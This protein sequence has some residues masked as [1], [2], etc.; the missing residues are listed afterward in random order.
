METFKQGQKVYHKSAGKKTFT[1]VRD[2]GGV[3]VVIKDESGFLY[4]VLREN[5]KPAEGYLEVDQENR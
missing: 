5:L 1:V 3:K 2:N 4:E